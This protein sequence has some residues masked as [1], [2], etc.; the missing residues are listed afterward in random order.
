MSDDHLDIKDELYDMAVARAKVKAA[1]SVER[2]TARNTSNCHARETAFRAL[3][4]QL[5]L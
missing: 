5:I 1:E 3:Y 2:P 4:N